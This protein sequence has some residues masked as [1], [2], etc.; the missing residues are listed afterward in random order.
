M[1]THITD[2]P[3]ATTF[4]NP[5]GSPP[6]MTP[7]QA[8]LAELDVGAAIDARRAMDKIAAAGP[9]ARGLFIDCGSNLGQGYKQ[10]ARHF[11]TRHFDY[12]LIEP[13]PN[14][15]PELKRLAAQ[16][17]RPHEI[18]AQ[19]A[20]TH[21]GSVKFFGLEQ[22]PTSQGGS[23]LAEHNSRY[24][25]ADDARALEVP[26]FSLADLIRSRSEGYA[27][28]VLKLDI[29]GGEYEVLPDLIAKQAHLL[30]DAAYIEFHSQYMAE[31]KATTYRALEAAI[32][33]KL[34]QDRV[35]Y[36]IWI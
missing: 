30:L 9:G 22:D 19:A 2:A 18:L 12:I 29:E 8:M 11:A 10:F 25:A 4:A 13:N 1:T 27:A 32:R 31:P 7:F 17:E 23:M 33:Q 15:L 36:R 24:Y 3:G 28:V 6:P 21:V 26:C 20:S 35:P 16:A 34:T 5:A 14:C